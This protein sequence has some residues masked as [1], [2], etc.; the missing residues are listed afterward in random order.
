MSYTVNIQSAFDKFIK[1]LAVRLILY[2]SQSINI[3]QNKV[4]AII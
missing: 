4:I 2:S 3:C 1:G